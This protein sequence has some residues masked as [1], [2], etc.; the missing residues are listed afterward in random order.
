MTHEEKVRVHRSRRDGMIT[1]AKEYAAELRN[2]CDKYNSQLKPY[3]TIA[4]HNN[5]SSTGIP[6]NCTCTLE[7]VDI[8]HAEPTNFFINLKDL[9]DV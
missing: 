2:V 1:L 4:I 6:F 7:L 3:Y 5:K 8:Y 9:Q